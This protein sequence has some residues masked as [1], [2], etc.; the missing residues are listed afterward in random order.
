MRKHYIKWT[1]IAISGVLLC[2]LCACIEQEVAVAQ[3][4][5]QTKEA[6]ELKQTKQVKQV[7]KPQPNIKSKNN[8]SSHMIPN[9]VAT[10]K[11]TQ[12]NPKD[13]NLKNDGVYP[14]SMLET[15][16]GEQSQEEVQEDGR[17]Y[18]AVITYKP[19]TKIKHGK[20]TLYYLDGALAQVAFYV[21][22]KREGLYQ[23]FSQRG[24]L[25][26]EAYY[27]G[28]V[29]HG[30]CRL[31][32]VKNGSLRSEMNFV[33]GTQEGEMKIYDTSGALWHSI[34][35]KNGKKNGIAK[36]FDENGK[37]VREVIYRDDI[38]ISR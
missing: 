25:I 16:S 31:F 21:D 36:E 34:E 7:V 27:N 3:A 20:E 5:K 14:Q 24:V 1:Q 37:I 17:T 8:L 13:I 23:I 6:K 28:G 18:Q 4:S 2:G 12:P 32:D 11:D 29:L 33:Y 22:G 26:Y 38:E 30:L 9:K 19:G 10:P 15:I 35:Y